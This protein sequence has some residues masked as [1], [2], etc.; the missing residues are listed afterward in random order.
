MQFLE[1]NEGGVKAVNRKTGE[2]GSSFY[3]EKATRARALLDFKFLKEAKHEETLH[4]S[5]QQLQHL[6]FYF[7]IFFPYMYVFYTISLHIY[8][9]FIFMLLQ[10]NKSSSA[11]R[12]VFSVYPESRILFFLFFMSLHLL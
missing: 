3:P 5:L 6:F 2:E 4:N 12:T 1:G 7:S 9:M 11:L 8:F 10:N